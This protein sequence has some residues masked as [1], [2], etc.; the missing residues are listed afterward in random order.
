MLKMVESASVMPPRP[1][2][3]AESAPFAGVAARTERAWRA[4]HVCVAG[5]G[6]RLDLEVVRGV[7]GGGGMARHLAL[8]TVAPASRSEW[9]PQYLERATTEMSAPSS[10][11]RSSPGD[12]YLA[13][14]CLGPGRRRGAD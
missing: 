3:R 6:L 13:G 10:S 8:A 2:P 9:P 4:G 1:P 14:S 12:P 5:P 11:G 7:W